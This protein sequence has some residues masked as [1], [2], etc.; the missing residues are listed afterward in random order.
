MLRTEMRPKGCSRTFITGY[1]PMEEVQEIM[2]ILIVD[3]SR[4]DRLTLCQAVKKS[5]IPCTI[6]EYDRPE[7]VLKMLVQAGRR[8]DCIVT[9]LEF[10]TMSGLDLYRKLSRF[11]EVPP[12]V[13][14]TRKESADTA[15]QAIRE[16]VYDYIV[17]DGSGAYLHMFPEVLINVIQKHRELQG[18]KQAGT[19]RKDERHD[20][21][22][23]LMKRTEQ[24]V[25]ANRRLKEEIIK[26]MQLEKELKE[27]QEM[28]ALFMNHFPGS[29]YMKDA[30][31]RIVYVNKYVTDAYGWKTDECIGKK[32][33]ELWPEKVAER[34][35]DDDREVFRTGKEL[36]KINEVTHQGKT[37]AYLTQKFPIYQNSTLKMVGGISLDITETRRLEHE[38]SL[39]VSAVENAKE[40]IFILDC[41]GRIRYVNAAAEHSRGLSRKKL[42]GKTYKY[43]PSLIYEHVPSRESAN[44]PAWP[45]QKQIQRKTRGDKI[46]HL[47]ILLSPI[48]DQE[49]KILFYTAMELDI[50]DEVTLRQK[51]E[52][53]QRME[54]LGS[55]ASGISHDLNNL[56][57][58]ILINAE[59]LWDHI[60]S[61]EEASEY[62]EE[63]ISAAHTGKELVKQIKFFIAR[64]ESFFKPISMDTAVRNAMKMIRRNLPAGITCRQWIG[65]R[66]VRIKAD[67]TQ[68]HQM[69]MN[70]CINAI[71]AMEKSGGLLHVSLAEA[72]IHAPTPSI[73]SIIKP[74]W[75]LKLSVRDTGEGISR[76][77]M[78]KIFSPHFTTRADRRGTGL[79]LAM[80]HTIVK[81]CGG[82]IRVYSREGKGTRFD[83]YLPEYLSQTQQRA[84]GDRE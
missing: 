3:E 61:D 77:V 45:I 81:N 25:R 34:I 27:Q 68:V 6:E 20:L 8:V 10:Q 26:R 18:R 37:L 62:L 44:A 83:V 31:G 75:Y 73:F 78:D 49:G 22:K 19:I 79:G 41:A 4:R 40:N 66:N 65:A 39:L 16:G 84:S 55:L 50:T 17:K 47:K 74:G 24:L 23:A 32:D 14:L 46:Q 33:S 35:E 56:L 28:Y 43:F 42:A 38:K 15:E 30:Q 52:L 12:L 53:P 60:G 76:T 36:R 54:L 21:E 58:P 2:H 59:L 72:R 13:I 57:Q 29:V 48:F 80:V 71:Q 9:E 7:A 11:P 64:K 70:L 63:I 1:N 51:L 5:A 69:V 82:A 67:S